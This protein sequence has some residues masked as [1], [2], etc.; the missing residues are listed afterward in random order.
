M[1]NKPAELQAYIEGS[2]DAETKKWWAQNAESH[3]DVKT[4]LKYYEEINDILSLV[5]IHC[6]T[7]NIVKSQELCALYPD[8]HAAAYFIGRHFEQE[9]NVDFINKWNDAISYY[10]KSKCFSSAIRLAKEHKI[11]NELMQLAIQSSPTHMLD[12][13][14]YFESLGHL[15]KAITL[16]NKGGNV[17]HAL[18]L[19]FKTNDIVLLENI[20]SQLDPQKDADAIQAA[21]KF[22]AEKG[23]HGIA[24]D[25]L[26]AAEKFDD[27]IDM[28][29]TQNITLSDELIDKI[30]ASESSN[31]SKSVQSRLGELCLKQGS[32]QLACK[33]FTSVRLI[34]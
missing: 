6:L 12:V 8:N 22:L 1:L 5:R 33:A 27:M 2:E 32:Y 13:G 31:V 29:E 18:N 24:L 30:Q 19:C 21:S 26:V 11:D 17:K 25:L 10:S 28:C 16:F 15:D 14:R 23:S 3:G 20:V 4:A 7:G 9:S 34:N